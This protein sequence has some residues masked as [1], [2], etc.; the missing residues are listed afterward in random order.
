M[1]QDIAPT[2][3]QLERMKP[4]RTKALGGNERECLLTVFGCASSAPITN[5]ASTFMIVQA[6]FGIQAKGFDRKLVVDSP[7]MPQLDQDRKSKSRQRYG[8]VSGAPH[9]PAGLAGAARRAKGSIP[10]YS[11]RGSIWRAMASARF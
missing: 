1:I 7:V 8:L 3:S 5:S 11:A 9:A 2:R 6:T 10:T 4:S